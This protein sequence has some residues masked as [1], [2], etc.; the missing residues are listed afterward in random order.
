MN[1]F[2]QKL[3]K[4]QTGSH[5]MVFD[6]WPK[7]WNK[8]A[9]SWSFPQTCQH[10]RNQS[11]NYVKQFDLQ[12]SAHNFRSLHG[13]GQINGCSYSGGCPCCGLAFKKKEQQK[14]VTVTLVCGHTRTVQRQQPLLLVCVCVD[15]TQ[16][17]RWGYLAIQRP[18]FIDHMK[19]KEKWRWPQLANVC[20][21]FFFFFFCNVRESSN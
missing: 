18:S 15:C 2:H 3:T 17:M 9:F 7:I 21:L 14:Q 16:I 4:F 8:E 19:V 6:F 10:I 1:L 11:I 20:S 5:H 12:Q 13:G